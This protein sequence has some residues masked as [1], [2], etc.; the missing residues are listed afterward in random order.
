MIYVETME[1]FLG[2][3]RIEADARWLLAISFTSEPTPSYPNPI[4]MLTRKWLRSYFQGVPPPWLPPLPPAPPFTTLVYE[5]LLES[6]L[7]ERWT[8]SQLARMVGSPK[9]YGSI[10]RILAANPYPILIP[11]HRILSKEGLGGYRWGRERKE[12]LLEFEDAHR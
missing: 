5:T 7:G 11:C 2:T 9:G 6:S 12:A 10:G 8:Y 4:T 3:I 1:S